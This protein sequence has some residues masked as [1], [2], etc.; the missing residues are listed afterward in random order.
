LDEAPFA[1]RRTDYIRE[2]VKDTVKV[3]KL[4]TPV[5][6]YKGGNTR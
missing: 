3:E 2:A 4:I 6:N 5:Y 1:Y